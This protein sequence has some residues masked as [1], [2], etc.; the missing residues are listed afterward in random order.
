MTEQREKLFRVFFLAVFLYLLYQIL[1]ILSPFFT[2]ILAAIVLSLIFFPL[3]RLILKSFRGQRN[4]ASVL[5]TTLVIVLIVIPFTFFFWLLLNEIT[6]LGPVVKK[7][8]S[9]IDQWRQEGTTIEIPWLRTLEVKLKS[10]LDLSQVDFQKMITDTAAA[11]VKEIVNFGKKIPKNA[12]AFIVNMLGMIFTLFFLFRDGPYLLEKV[13]ELV[14][15]EKKHKDQIATQLYLTVTAVVRGVFIVSAAQGAVAGIGFAIAGVPSAL[16]LGFATVFAA[17]IPLVGPG[18][19]WLP[20]AIYYMFQGVTWQWIFLLLW[21]VLVVSLV[22]NFL[23]PLI[24]G[25]RAKL[26]MLFLFFGI[27]GGVKM[28]G[29]MGIFLGPLVLALVMAFINIY[30]EKYQ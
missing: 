14:P 12:F 17:M 27:L 30:R 24:I 26:P 21:G 1:C 25:S 16:V 4:L 2:G 18:V 15:M 3:H 29:P 19:I 28:Y 22:D 23:R 11:I 20:V 8:A 13:K 10:V 9:T 5:S 6:Q 7:F